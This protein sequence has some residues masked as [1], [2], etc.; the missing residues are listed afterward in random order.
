[1]TVAE[2]V[3]QALRVARA[4]APVEHP[5]RKLMIVRE[6]YR[7]DYPT[8][9]IHQVEETELGRLGESES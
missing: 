7:S 3:R 4:G 6:A 5:K 2:W 1:M 9:D 8:A